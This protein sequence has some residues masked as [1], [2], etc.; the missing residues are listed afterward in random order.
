MVVQIDS[1][2]GS[3]SAAAAVTSGPVTA[4]GE[5]LLAAAQRAG[6]IRGDVTL[7]HALDL[8]LAVVRLD[9]PPEEIETVLRVALDG[10]RA[11]G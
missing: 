7:V 2:A 10:L 3:P 8:V 4:P 5:P 9:R 1:A 6:H 11:T